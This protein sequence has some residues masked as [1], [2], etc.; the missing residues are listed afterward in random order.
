[1]SSCLIRCCTWHF[2]S[3]VPPGVGDVTLLRQE[4]AAGPSPGPAAATA[5]HQPGF[6]AQLLQG[7]A[8]Q[9]LNN[10][11]KN[12]KNK[13][14]KKSPILARAYSVFCTQNFFSCIFLCSLRFNWHM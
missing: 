12:S 13:E 1:M 9:Q 10:S 7:Q 5:A 11:L 14:K 3:E 4:G 6:H 2:N 8:L